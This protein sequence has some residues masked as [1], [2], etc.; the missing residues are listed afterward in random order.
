MDMIPNYILFA[1]GVYLVFGSC[2]FIT[3]N[4]L[5]WILFV[6]IPFFSGI[7]I[8]FYSLYLLGFLIKT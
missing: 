4:M 2:Q 6:I 7:F 1:I 8:M 5:S 3:K